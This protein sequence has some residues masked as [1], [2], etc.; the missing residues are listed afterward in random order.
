MSVTGLLYLYPCV[1]VPLL[2]GIGSL[3]GHGA[4]ARATTERNIW[5]DFHIS[6]DS[7][8]VGRYSLQTGE[9]IIDFI[10]QG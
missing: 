7:S 3:V 9:W 5:E 2:Q 4:A 10:L 6:K 1:K 8:R